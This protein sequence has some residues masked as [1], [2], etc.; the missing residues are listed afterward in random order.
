MRPN[1]RKYLKSHE[2]AKREGD[3]VVIG[4]TDFAVAELND[5]VFLDLPTVG[6]TL[7]A[8]DEFGEI[9]SVKAVSAMYSPVSGTISAVNT[10]LADDLEVLA[11][12]P[13]GAGWMIKLKPSKIAEYDGLLDAA[14][15]EKNTAAH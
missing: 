11:K 15:Y 3:L 4:I 14:A 8:G 12:D 6:K 5:L 2:W 10:A 7:K 1:D 9:E 13:F